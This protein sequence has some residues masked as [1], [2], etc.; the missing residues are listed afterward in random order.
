M[1]HAKSIKDDTTT[2]ANIFSPRWQGNNS[3]EN[4]HIKMISLTALRVYVH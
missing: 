2:I 3:P 1:K 4:V